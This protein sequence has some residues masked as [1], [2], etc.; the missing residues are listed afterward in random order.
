MYIVCSNMYRRGHMSLKDQATRYISNRLV[1]TTKIFS[2]S[3]KSF[4]TNTS[5]V[6]QKII[7]FSKNI[8]ALRH[9]LSMTRNF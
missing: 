8:D 6:I 9:S 1:L 7:S 3:R 4:F 2:A 5:E